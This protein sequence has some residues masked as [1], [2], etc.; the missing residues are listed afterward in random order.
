MRSVIASATVLL[1]AL[2]AGAAAGAGAIP[3]APQ[4]PGGQPQVPGV[5]DLGQPDDKAKFR[6]VVEG[7]QH[8]LARVTGAVP[9]G[10]CSFEFNVTND[11]TWKFERGRGV[12]M[13]FERFNRIVLMRR[14]GHPAG[15]TTLAL[16]GTV[17]RTSAGGY[18]EIGPPPCRGSFPSNQTDCNTS[19]PVNS[20]LSLFWSN[21]G[22]LSLDRTG[23]QGLI[24]LDDSQNPAQLCGIDD[25]TLDEAY[26]LY[27]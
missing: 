27:R 10:N 24:D 2:G 22:K 3:G 7:S 6:L 9:I 25:Q 13:V 1:I 17:A 14:Q 16:V 20:P 18:N 8:A 12:T 4:I 21:K 11:E 26:F 19:F 5:P 15:D 23:S